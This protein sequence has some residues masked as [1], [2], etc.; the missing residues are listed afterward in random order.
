MF[1]IRSR[2]ASV[3]ATLPP[4]RRH[5]R[6]LI[7]EDSDTDARLEGQA[8]ERYGIRE[9]KAVDSA[10]QALRRLD[11]ETFNVALLDYSL[12]RMNGL[13]LLDRIKERYPDLRVIL[14]TGARDEQVAVAAMK[15]GADD[16][17]TKDEF[18]ATGIIS[19][20]QNTL[21]SIE[22][23]RKVRVATASSLEA[24]IIEVEALLAL[25]DLPQDDEEAVTIQEAAIWER[26]GFMEDLTRLILASNREPTEV[27]QKIE[28]RLIRQLGD[29]DASPRDIARLHLAALK[30]IRRDA[31]RSAMGTPDCSPMVVLAHLLMGVLE[32]CRNGDS[33]TDP[34]EGGNVTYW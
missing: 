26:G 27:E 15:L 18:L 7:V 5:V 28:A 25:D 22:E 14:V 17:I 1:S 16:Y 19:S 30:V 6:V 32:A 20:L 21:R 29:C 8:L 11:K 3:E 24:G 13:S 12:P 31:F 23:Q 2:N 34:A 10:E 4:N 9:W 33:L